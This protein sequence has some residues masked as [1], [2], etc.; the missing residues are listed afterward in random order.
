MCLS[1]VESD[2]G[3]HLWNIS[4]QEFNEFLKCMT[5][6]FPRSLEKSQSHNTN[7]ATEMT[8]VCYQTTNFKIT[9]IKTHGSVSCSPR[10]WRATRE[11]I[12]RKKENAIVT[13]M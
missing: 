8:T 10:S 13:P 7:C 5:F 9:N 6:P 3:E 1:Q 11:Y 2:N 12:N 4:T